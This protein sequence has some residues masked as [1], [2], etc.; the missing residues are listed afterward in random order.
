M[1][2]RH[3]LGPYRVCATDRASAPQGISRMRCPLPWRPIREELLV[4]GPVSGDGL[5]LTHLSRE[6]AGHRDLFGRGGQAVPHGLS[7]ERGTLNAGRRQRIARLAHLRRLRTDTD[8]HRPPLVCP[9]SDGRRSGPEPVCV[10][11]D[12]HRSMSGTVSVGPVPAAQ[13]GGQDA[14]AAGSAPASQWEELSNTTPI[15]ASTNGGTSR[16]DRVSR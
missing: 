5:R 6:L 15:A 11:F 12:D 1:T 3:E 7:R 10:G 8:C 16:K 14:H 9:G 13:G 2:M 4:L